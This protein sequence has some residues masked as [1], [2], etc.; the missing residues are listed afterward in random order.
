MLWVSPPHI[1]LDVRGP[2]QCVPTL[3][4][5]LD[6]PRVSIP[7]CASLFPP[8][9]PEQHAAGPFRFSNEFRSRHA[10]TVSSIFFF[11]FAVL[12][13]SFDPCPLP[14]IR[15]KTIVSFVVSLCDVC[16]VTLPW[17][18]AHSLVAAL[19]FP[20]PGMLFFFS[21]GIAIWL[22]LPVIHLFM[23]DPLQAGAIS[24]VHSSP[25][26]LDSHLNGLA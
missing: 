3:P 19:S 2:S 9:A 26:S 25:S 1:L 14:P 11:I 8:P 23:M 7:I 6:G 18:R 20:P 22:R 4:C 16:P 5:G 24:F 12:H 10:Q 21:P 13:S 17:L 15:T